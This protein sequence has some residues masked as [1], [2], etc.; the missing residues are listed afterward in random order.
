MLPVLFS[1]FG[2]TVYT[3][4]IFAVVAFFWFLYVFWR[5]ARISVHREHELFDVLL[6]S[7]LV[8]LVVG[9]L[10]YVTMNI[11]FFSSKSIIA[12][13]ALHLFP[14]IHSLSGLIGGL[15]ALLMFS[16]WRKLPP[17]EV[18]ALATPGLMVACSIVSIGQLFSG[19]EVGAVTDFPIRVKY[20]LYDGLRHAVGLYQ[21]LYF[22]IAAFI[23]Q[24]MFARA[25]RMGAKNEYGTV[26][27]L[28]I[29][30]VSF[31]QIIFLPLKDIVL[32]RK[33][34]VIYTVNLLIVSITLLTAMI[35]ILY[36]LRSS[37]FRLPGGF[38]APKN[39]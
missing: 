31:A 14:G 10:A 26:T 20:S 38:L 21:A 36:Y 24:R 33:D 32:L 28:G 1:Q 22:A 11:T 27:A 13:F 5:N 34:V 12:V 7:A 18:A 2:I 17:L 8:A 19:A 23:V 35:A 30:F 3:F 29:W 9:R 39:K 25:R 6:L 4:G 15:V 16:G 37:L